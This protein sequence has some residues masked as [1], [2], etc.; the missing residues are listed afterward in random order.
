MSAHVIVFP[1]RPVR[2]FVVEQLNDSQWHIIVEPTGSGPVRA[3]GVYCMAEANRTVTDWARRFGLPVLVAWK[4]HPRMTL[5][6][7]RR[8]VP[9]AQGGA[10]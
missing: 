1:R 9:M 6:Q 2:A 8:K 3:S 7:A 5:N 10:A 4:H